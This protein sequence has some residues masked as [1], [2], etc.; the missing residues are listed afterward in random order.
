MRRQRNILIFAVRNS[1][2]GSQIQLT[3]SIF[4]NVKNKIL[5]IFAWDTYKTYYQI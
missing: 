3:T 2:Y 5:E 1:K 4:Q